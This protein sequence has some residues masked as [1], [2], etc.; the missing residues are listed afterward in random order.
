V[1]D[2]ANALR[3]IAEELERRLRLKTHP[4][5][6]RLLTDE[7]AIPADALRPVRDLG[8]HLSLC[9]A[10]EMARREGA[11]VAMLL[12]DHWCAEPV[13]GYGLGEPPAFFLEGHNRF[14]GDVATLE[15][16][17][18]YAEELPRLAV[19]RYTGTLSG[20]LGSPDIDPDV[21]LVYCDAAQLS[22]LLL[23][24]EY[25]DGRNLPVSL[26]GHAACVYGVVPALLSGECQVAVPCGGDRYRAM[27]ADDEMVF[28]VPAGRLEELMIG[29]RAIE[30]AGRKLPN[31]YSLLPEYPLPES[32]RRIGEEMGYLPREPKDRG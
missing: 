14:P 17:A 23:A 29:L 20:P 2:R 5:A 11:T 30:A 12:E 22:V 8:R 4:I 21:V 10:F 24:R 26:S 16:G 1:D 28:G 19:G 31:G 27:A 13:I 32:Y 18:A 25:R 9:Q 3:D 7:S 6:L 15:A